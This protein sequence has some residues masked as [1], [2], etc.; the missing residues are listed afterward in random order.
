MIW[1][2]IAVAAAMALPHFLCLERTEPAVAIAI[3]LSALIMRALSAVLVV[4]VALFYLPTTALYTT[5]T[6][7]CWHGVLPLLSDHIGVSGHQ[8]GDVAAPLPL[9]AV[10]G[11]L[12]AMTSSLMLTAYRL[13]RWLDCQSLGE[14]P[15]GSTIVPGSGLVLATTGLGRSRVVVSTGALAA[16]D[17]AELA[18]GVEHER[19]HIVRGH[20][21]LLLLSAIC[22]SLARFLPGTVSVADQRAMHVERDADAY[23]LAQHHD[24][25]ALASAIC[26]SALFP[27]GPRALI[28]LHGHGAV[29]TRLRLLLD[30]PSTTRPRRAAM[31][32]MALALVAVVVALTAGVSIAA[33]DAAQ[34]LKLAPGAPHCMG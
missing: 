16:L 20:R 29:A 6:Q 33:A 1:L 3:C 21:A 30:S 15:H 17:D 13:R 5:I 23:A 25:L 10:A 7:W 18:A 28:A 8:V 11:P 14:G 2:L 26:K 34:H 22:G 31:R 32:G 19:G 12:I 9:L 4:I 24:R 27:S